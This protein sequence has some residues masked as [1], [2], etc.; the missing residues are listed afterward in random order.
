VANTIIGNVGIGQKFLD[1]SEDPSVLSMALDYMDADTAANKL[2]SL[3]GDTTSLTDTIRQRAAATQELLPLISTP[4][5][6]LPTDLAAD[7]ENLGQ[8]ISATQL[9]SPTASDYQGWYDDLQKSQEEDTATVALAGGNAKNDIDLLLQFSGN[10][11]QLF[12][13][14]TATTVVPP[15][16]TI[17]HWDALDIVRTS[18]S[19]S[20]QAPGAATA[21]QQGNGSAGVTP[22]D[23]NSDS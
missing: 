2:R 4:V 13:Q 22:D 14:F 10:A 19:E 23:V 3:A 11:S 6:P 12:A 1:A 15:I 8:T 5:T 18:G 7:L 9:S 17:N 20:S 21:Q 16:K